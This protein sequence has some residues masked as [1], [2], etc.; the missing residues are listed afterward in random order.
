MR[1]TIHTPHSETYP[2][3]KDAYPTPDNEGTGAL[4]IIQS[5][6]DRTI[7]MFPA[8]QRTRYIPA[9]ENT[10]EHHTETWD[11]L[12]NAVWTFIKPKLEPLGD[13]SRYIVGDEANPYRAHRNAAKHNKAGVR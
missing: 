11:E 5:G 7:D 1:F 8:G 12:L 13:G 4:H 6:N 10:E 9:E 2:T 3:P